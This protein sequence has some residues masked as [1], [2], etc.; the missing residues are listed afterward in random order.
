MVRDLRNGGTIEDHPNR[1]CTCISAIRRT[2]R[3]HATQCLLA[4]MT[5]WVVI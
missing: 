4:Y 2:Y 1:A 5:T 3:I